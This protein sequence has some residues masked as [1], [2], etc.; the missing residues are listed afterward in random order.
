MEEILF[1]GI[2]IS[3]SFKNEEQ[4][5]AFEKYCKDFTKGFSF[6][7]GVKL[8]LYTLFALIKD[9]TYGLQE[10]LDKIKDDL[11]QVRELKNRT[12]DIILRNVSS[13]IDKELAELY[14]KHYYDIKEKIQSKGNYSNQITVL[15]DWKNLKSSIKSKF[16]IRIKNPFVP[17][18]RINVLGGFIRLKREVCEAFIKKFLLSLFPT[19]TIAF[20]P[21]DM[22]LIINEILK[23][24]NIEIKNWQIST[25]DNNPE[26]VIEKAT[27]VL[28]SKLGYW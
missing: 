15:I 22:D 6:S 21:E 25:Q 26:E 20:R 19:K 4:K 10:Q 1:N 17:G 3:T 8:K 2:K 16:G 23:N 9:G 5:E 13:E 18:K 24:Y 14:E 7:D 11:D 28:L 12:Y 27:N